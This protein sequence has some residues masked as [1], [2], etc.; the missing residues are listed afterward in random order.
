MKY[1]DENKTERGERTRVSHGDFV[2]FIGIEPNLPLPALEY[3]GG[4]PL[5]ELQR[6]HFFFLSTLWKLLAERDW[7]ETC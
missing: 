6:D 3:A 5:L 7:S 2:D 1:K 4:E